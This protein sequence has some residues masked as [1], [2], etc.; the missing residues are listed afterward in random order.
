VSSD[1]SNA[2]LQQAEAIEQ[3][4]SVV[5]SSTGNALKQQADDVEQRLTA[6]S[7]ST[8]DALRQQADEVEHRLTTLSSSTSQ[9]LKQQADEVEE[10]LTAVSADTGSVLTQRAAEVEQRLTAV[11]TDTSNVLSQKADEVEQRLTAVSSGAGTVLKQNAAEVERVLLGASAEVV[12]SVSA[13]AEELNTSI[14]QRALELARLLDDRSGAFLSAFGGRGQ[15]FA[16]DVERATRQAVQALETKGLTFTKEVMSHSEELARMI[17]DAAITASGSVGRTIETLETR[18]KM[19]TEQSQKTAAAAVSE[20][21]DTHNMLRND[22]TALF[23]RLREANVLLQEV[24]GGATANL[25]AIE[26]TLSSRVREF[27]ATMNEVA[28]RSGA[29]NTKVE[30]HIKSFHAVT[31]NVLRDITMLAE[32]FDAQGRSLGA[33]A[34]LINSSNRRAE[35]L[36]AERNKT[37]GTLVNQLDGKTNDLD[38]RLIRFAGL[39]KDSFE[40]A[41]ARARD[42]AQIIAE[43]SADGAQAIATQ[44][45]LVRSAADEERKRTAEALR[46][47]YEQATGDTHALFRQASDRFAEIVREMKS[48][49]SEIQHELDSTRAE[50]RRGI[51]ELPQETAENAAEMRR[52]IVEQVEALAELNRIVARHARGAEMAEPVRRGVRDESAAA[53]SG[54]R[55]ETARPARLEIVGGGRQP[56]APPPVVTPA[57]A[58]PPSRRSEAPPAPPQ[59]EGTKDGGWL[60]D[61]LARASREESANAQAKERPARIESLDSLSIDIARMI[62]HDAA[63]E[64]WDRYKRGERNVFTKRLYTPQGQKTFDEIRKRYRGDREF[65]QTVDRYI[66]EF[67][68]LL[69]D[70]SRDDRGSVVARTYLTSETGKVYTMLAHAAGRFD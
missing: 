45:D 28:D 6:V 51:L 9:A 30:D 48:M 29:A 39:L 2:I 55:A 24:L 7:A 18:A 8:S 66:T 53:A 27:V 3:R 68:R 16:G 20:M 37:L 1:A 14:N 10:R 69:D 21:L 59:A 52:V 23:E 41:E 38:Q 15:Q 12:R 64:L 34:E 5:S 62:D 26:N 54:V 56:S 60:S 4:L 31:S 42:I 50:L 40:A 67:E 11:S 47:I 36:V 33:A 57:P 13:K 32:R 35:D 22:T 70:V 49:G 63:I 25:S 65:K 44:H 61:L 46:A 58:P 19:A 43:S 17:N